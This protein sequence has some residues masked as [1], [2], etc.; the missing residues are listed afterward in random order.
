M[1]NN[2]PFTIFLNSTCQP[3]FGPP[4]AAPVTASSSEASSESDSDDSD[5]SDDT[6]LELDSSES[7]EPSE[8]PHVTLT[9][10]V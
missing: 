1:Y 7:S 5:D 3:D 4:N 9:T 6:E 10:T 2:A 8:Q